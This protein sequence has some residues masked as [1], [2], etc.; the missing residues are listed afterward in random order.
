MSD[1]I[2][3]TRGG[4]DFTLESSVLSTLVPYA[5]SFDF[6]H[7]FDKASDQKKGSGSPIADYLQRQ[8]LYYGEFYP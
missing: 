2:S 3:R 4:E 6:K 7:E 1:E 5:S 8:L